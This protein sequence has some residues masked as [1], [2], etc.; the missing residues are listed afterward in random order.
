MRL[1]LVTQVHQ[2]LPTVWAGFNLALF[3][4]LNPPFPPVKVIRFDGC[5]RGDVVHLRLNFLLFQQD[6]IS[7]I[8]DQQQTD[9]EIFFV[10]KG[11]Q[12]PFFLSFWQHH[13]GLLRVIDEKNGNQ[14]SIIDD[15]TFKTPFLLTDYILYPLLWLQ[16][17]Y[18]RPIYRRVFGQ[19]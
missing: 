6:W 1:R 9:T 15:I 14:T 5:L 12:L 3:E 11:I 13:H 8:V 7:H 18:R 17:A 4:R 10:D 2:S 19:Q 16:F